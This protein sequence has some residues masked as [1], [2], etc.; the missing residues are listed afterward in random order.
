MTIELTGPDGN[1]FFLLA[2]ARRL[3]R[4]LGL[5]QE[6]VYT[7]M[8]GGDYVHLVNTLLEYFGDVITLTED[9]VE[10]DEYHG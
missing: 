7:K 6:E 10:I 4:E 3:S 9:G 8:T 5:P 2:Q 1:A